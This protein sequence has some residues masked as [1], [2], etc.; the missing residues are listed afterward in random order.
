[1]A[2]DPADLYI[3]ARIDGNVVQALSQGTGEPFWDQ[4][5][6]NTIY[7]IRLAAR[8]TGSPEPTLEEIPALLVN[9]T[10]LDGLFEAAAARTAGT[11]L[12]HDG[13][14]NREWLR[15][16]WRGLSPELRNAIT[17]GFRAAARTRIP[18]NGTGNKATV[19]TRR[20]PWTCEGKLVADT[21]GLPSEIRAAIERAMAQVLPLD[22]EDAPKIEI[23][24]HRLRKTAAGILDTIDNAVAAGAA[25]GIIT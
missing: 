2:R 9:D 16:D 14:A 21:D 20:E 7:R 18:M 10:V 23:D 15:Y 22:N 19:T 3:D 5:Y 11:E 24:S 4:A 8:Q 13:L 1:M 17:E 25:L 12:E 6:T